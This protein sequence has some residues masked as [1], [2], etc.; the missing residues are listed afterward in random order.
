MSKGKYRVA[1]LEDASPICRQLTA[2]WGLEQQVAAA[3]LKDTGKGQQPPPLPPPLLP[4]RWGSHVV[5]SPRSSAVHLCSISLC[6]LIFGECV[7]EHGCGWV[8]PLTA[9]RGQQGRLDWGV[10]YVPDIS[11]EHDGWVQMR[12]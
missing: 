4:L 10:Y 6:Q 11:P 12:S 3:R 2:C 1:I 8:I 5:E 7:D 9:W